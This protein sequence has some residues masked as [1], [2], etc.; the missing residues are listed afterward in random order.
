M[1]GTSYSQP[2]DPSLDTYGSVEVDSHE[3]GHE[4]LDINVLVSL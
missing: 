2:S 3:D 1:P 4:M